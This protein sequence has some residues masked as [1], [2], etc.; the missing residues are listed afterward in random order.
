MKSV[1]VA[2]ARNHLTELLRDAE[3]GWPVTIERRGEAVA[4]LL[5]AADYEQLMRAASA[6]DFAA[7]C[8]RWRERQSASF[9][10]ISNDEL[11]RWQ[12]LA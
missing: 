8:Q 2:E 4:V 11:E 3:N 10:G 5:S 7:W 1:S 9:D 6:G 12:E